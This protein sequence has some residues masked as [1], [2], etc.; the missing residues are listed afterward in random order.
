MIKAIFSNSSGVLV[1]RVFGFIRDMLMASTLGVNIFT[2]IF[3]VAFQLPN[4]FRRIFGEGAF[5]QAFI[6]SFVRAKRKILFSAVVFYKLMFALLLLTSTVFIFDFEVTKTIAIGFS[7]ENIEKATLFVK[8]NFLYLT[9]IFLVTFLSA[10][11]HYKEHFATTSF[12]T[13]L[14]NLSMITALLFAKGEEPEI[15]IYILSISVIVGGVL[16]VLA[17]I[18]AIHLKSLNRVAFGGLNRVRDFR[19]VKRESNR[20]FNKFFLAIWGGATAQ[21][22]SFLDTLIA[23]F[24]VT[25]SISYLYYANRIFQFPLALFAIAISV[26]IFPKVSKFLKES[27]G[28]ERAEKIFQNSFWLLLYL[29]LSATMVGIYFSEE[30]VWLLYERGA[31]SRE[32]TLNTAVVLTFYLMG[33]SIFG[34]AKLFSLW[35]FAKEKI[36]TSAKIATY[37]LFIKIFFAIILIQ[38]FGVSG[39]ALS[40]TISSLFLLLFTLHEFGWNRFGRVLKSRYALFLFPYLGVLFTILYISLELTK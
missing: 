25:G 35:L 2:D 17:H 22:S 33:L 13:V 19:K 12:S 39:L 16:Q 31:F 4:L 40:T 36:G 9:L 24:L 30:I 10:F 7:D 28:E 3:F 1:S 18:L 6:P 20:F 29:L 5:S 32:D 38:D 15:A 11:L 21:I 14:L 23:S 8:I 26:A 37:A 34:V 27:S